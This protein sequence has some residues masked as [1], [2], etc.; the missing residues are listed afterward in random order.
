MRLQTELSKNDYLQYQ[1]YMASKRKSTRKERIKSQI[2]VSLFLCITGFLLASVNRNKNYLIAFGLASIISFIVYPFLLRS[3]YKR[4]FANFINEN[5]GNKTGRPEIL[6]IKNGCILLKDNKSETKLKIKEIQEIVEI[7]T[8]YFIMI[9]STAAII[10]TKNK[11][12]SDFINNLHEKHNLKYSSEL[13][14]RW[15]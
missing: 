12:T 7:S 9:D 15:K 8:N 3:F 4:H 5:Y 13:N 11:A 14:W 1:L 10:L 6:E 2:L